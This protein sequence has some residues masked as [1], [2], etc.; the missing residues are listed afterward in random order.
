MALMDCN[1]SLWHEA[2][3]KEFFHSVRVPSLDAQGLLHF[4]FLVQELEGGVRP[5]LVL[6]LE[7]WKTLGS[8]A[9]DKRLDLWKS[10]Q[11][12]ATHLQNCLGIKLVI[13]S[14]VVFVTACLAVGH[15]RL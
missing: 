2:L 14:I 7:I 11:F 9:L 4:V 6:Y 10:P 13:F 8:F 1:F 3:P 5:A 12:S 15:Q